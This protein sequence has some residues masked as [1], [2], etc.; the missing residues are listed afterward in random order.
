[1]NLIG[2]E[3]ARIGNPH[4]VPPEMDRVLPVLRDVSGYSETAFLTS[5]N[6]DAGVGLFIHVGRCQQDLDMWWAQTMAFLPDGRVAT[7]RSYGRAP[8]DNAHVQTGNLR[9]EM[10]GEFGVWRSRF[11][12]AAEIVTPA[13]LTERPRGAGVSRPMSWEFST[14]AAGPIWDMYAAMGRDFT[15]DWAKGGHAQQVLNIAGR[16]TVDGVEYPLDGTAANDHSFGPRDMGAVGH[17]HFLIGGYPGGVIHGFSAFSTDGQPLVET[18]SH[19]TG[20]GEH[21]AVK[22]VD[23]PGL[24][25][26]DQIDG[27]FEATMLEADGTKVSIHIE[28]LNALSFTVTDDGDNINGVLWD[29]PDL[30]AILENRVKIILPDGTVGFAHLERSA[31]RS[32]L[33]AGERHDGPGDRIQPVGM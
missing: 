33:H 24:E 10:L 13:E 11:D 18:G 32:Q 25:R 5:W 23:I 1:M 7:D 2:L 14:T 4:E 8:A 22:I 19:V 26:L 12:G 20:A 15:L 29:G 27:H 21:N 16:L 28:L 30:L 17:H 31:R 3:P 6:P 9:L